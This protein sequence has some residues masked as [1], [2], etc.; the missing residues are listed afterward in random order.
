M[1]L[2]PPSAGSG[3]AQQVFVQETAPTVAYPCIWVVTDS[4]GN[5]TGEIR[6][7]TSGAYPV[8][9]DLGVPAAL[10]DA[11]GD[12]IVGTGND[13]AARLPHG[14]SGQ[15]LAVNTDGSLH[16]ID[17]PTGGGGGMTNPMTTAA[18][19]IVGGASGAPARLAKGTTGQA[20][21]V[22][23][24][25]SLA[26]ATPAAGGLSDLSVTPRL[27]SD[28]ARA[29]WLPAGAVD[30]TI[31][32]Y[33]ATTGSIATTSGTLLLTGGCV[34][35]G[36]RTVSTISFVSG[37][38]GPGTP[39]NQW[40]CLVDRATRQVL[41]V[42]A[43]DGATAWGGGATKTLTLT[44]PFTPA[45]AVEAY[46]GLVNVAATATQLRGGTSALPVIGLG[47]SPRVGT[48][49]TGLTTPLAVGT[50]VNAPSAFANVPY[51]AILS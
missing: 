41:A 33:A 9:D 23:A 49:N 10:I 19:L 24:D 14:T 34:I 7:E 32:W 22:Q 18:D 25:G 37:T 38:A 20:L 11:L 47:G 28:F 51:A 46:V 3:G 26:W 21:T 35:P 1:G 48:S 2:R 6:A 42:T 40:F 44:T 27:L 5:P 50:V 36:G 39:T 16:W 12:L 43:D 8:V 13:T 4:A 17:A 30:E 45:N 29:P 15:V 31:P